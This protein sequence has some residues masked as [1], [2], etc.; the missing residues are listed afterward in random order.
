MKRR[1]A[2]LTRWTR[3]LAAAL[4]ERKVI[5]LTAYVDRHGRLQQVLP[6]AG[7]ESS[8]FKRAENETVSIEIASVIPQTPDTWQVDWIET[9]RD[10]VA[11]YQ[12]A[13]SPASNGGR[14]LKP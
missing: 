12:I 14:G 11:S 6:V 10:T 2:L 5:P 13:V 3:V 7:A 1:T 4:S 9:T 8:P